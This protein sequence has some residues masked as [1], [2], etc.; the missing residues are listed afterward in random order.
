MKQG[1][2][3]KIIAL[4]FIL[5]LSAGG[6]A[7]KEM[8][9]DKFTLI[10]REYLKR[11]FEESFDE[12]QSTAQRE[13]ILKNILEDYGVDLKEFKAYMKKEKEDKYLEI[14]HN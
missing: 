13:K 6:C 2:E 11:E 3:V 1:T 12:K 10:W 7:K 8:T 14:F 5:V 9:G 4:L